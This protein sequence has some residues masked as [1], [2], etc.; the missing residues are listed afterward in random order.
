VYVP[1]PTSVSMPSEPTA[2]AGVEIVDQGSAVCPKQPSMC[3]EAAGPG[4]ANFCAA[5]S[6][7]VAPGCE[8]GCCVTSGKCRKPLCRLNGL[9]EDVAALDFICFGANR[10]LF[11]QLNK[12][13][14]LRCKLTVPGCRTGPFGG[15]CVGYVAVDPS[16][17]QPELVL[18]PQV[19]RYIGFPCIEVASPPKGPKLPPFPRININVNLHTNDTFGANLVDSGSWNSSE[20]QSVI[21]DEDYASGLWTVCDCMATQKHPS[22]WHTHISMLLHLSL[23]TAWS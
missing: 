18:N 7:F 9:G 20:P 14:G 17:P 15:N 21:S 16:L 3:S 13:A 4:Q 1:V 10:G 2:Q 8:G 22:K 23:A 12:C 6:P 11:S 5:V 19:V